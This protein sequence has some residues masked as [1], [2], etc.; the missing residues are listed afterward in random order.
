LAINDA[1]IAEYEKIYGFQ[2]KVGDSLA[3]LLA[4]RPALRKPVLNVWS[5]ALAGEA[6]TAIERFGDPALQ[7]PCYEITFRPLRDAAGKIIGAYQFSTDITERREAEAR[8]TAA[9]EQLRQSQKME[10]VGRLTGG[11]AHDFNNVLQVIGGNLQLLIR[12]VAGNLRAEHR[13]QTAFAAI[14]RGSKLASQLLAFAR[15]QPLAPK[16][17]NVGDLIRGIEDMLRRALGDGVEIETMISGGLWNTFVDSVQVENALLNL[18]INARDAME[19]HGNLTIEAGNVHL[20]GDYAAR[21]AD[22]A[23][24]EYVMITVTDT[25]CGIPSDIVA[26]V[27]EPFFTTKPEGQGTGLGLSMVYG[28]VK[29]SGG[30]IQIYSEPDHGTAV[31]IYLP[32][33]PEFETAETNIETGSAMG[34]TETILLVEDDEEVRG[35]V[36]DML[37]ELGYRVLKARDAQ[38]GLAIVESGVHIDLLFTD[39]VMPGLLRSPELARKARERLP[40]VAVLFTSGYTA[41]AIIHSGRLDD[42]IEL[43][44]KPYTREALARKI[45]YVLRNERQP[46]LVIDDDCDLRLLMQDALQAEGYKVSVAGDGE[47]GIKLQRKQPASLLIT[48]IFMPNKEGV[49]TIRDFRQEFPNVPIIAMSGGG[50]PNSRAGGLFTAKELGAQT[51]LQKPFQIHELLRSVRAALKGSEP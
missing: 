45:R 19:G 46:I 22:V 26:R 18:A 8:L 25:G 28:F 31:R 13:L 32:R 36:V 42:G 3:D 38:S 24:G 12:D 16:V 15:R 29:Q 6:F 5:R 27:F 23:A 4:D 34:G 49:E 30:H 2:P 9:E 10:A 41:T 50:R 21:H 37:S 1:A 47:Q 44:S 43:L 17:I 7:R 40:N 33:T 20:N 48:D 14:S 35:T 51:I 11:V 39:V